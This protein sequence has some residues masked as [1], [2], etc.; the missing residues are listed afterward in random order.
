MGLDQYALHIDAKYVRKD[1]QTDF[2]GVNPD[3]F[4]NF[5]Q[6]RKHS[7]LQGWME[8]LYQDKG[9]FKVPFN[10]AK[11]RI[12][13]A[14]LEKLKEAVMADELP[15]TQGFFFGASTPE[16]M[17]DDLEFIQ[18]AKTLIKEGKVII[19]DSWW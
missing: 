13:F 3:L 2:D 17:L 19:Y 9:G 15:E 4:E 6:W 1:C 10:C 14:D 5:H 16:D 8:K 11:V 7:N 12:T 18:K